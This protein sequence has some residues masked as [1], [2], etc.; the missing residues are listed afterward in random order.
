MCSPRSRTVAR[1][2]SHPNRSNGCGQR[3]H[4]RRRRLHGADQRG[5][6]QRHRDHQAEGCAPP[7]RGGRSRSSSRPGAVGDRS[8]FDSMP[9]AVG[10]PTRRW[11]P[12][13]AGRSTLR[14]ARNQR[15]A[16]TDRRG[17]CGSPVPVAVD[18]SAR[19]ST[20]SVGRRQHR[21]R[22]RHQAPGSVGPICHAG[23]PPHSAGVTPIVTSMID[24]ANP[25]MR[26]RRRR[27]R[28]HR[29]H[30]VATSALWPPASPP[31][32]VEDGASSC[33]RSPDSVCVRRRAVGSSRGLYIFRHGRPVRQT[34]DEDEALT[35]IF[36]TWGSA[37]RSP[38]D[39]LVN[40]ASITWCRRRCD[41]RTPTAMR[42]QRCSSR[43]NDSRI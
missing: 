30:G 6:R 17:R 1:S 13:P 33:R 29:S 28:R 7:C 24:S 39:Y 43:S 35:L 20:I 3:H 10:A 9:T 27:Q 4:R 18:E 31:A 12:A 16:S 25:R 34:V 19:R 26:A 38:R 5:D 11:D 22:G 32:P 36:P 8:S 37:G 42:L 41:G 21:G 23:D 2:I 14:S 15:P 40:T